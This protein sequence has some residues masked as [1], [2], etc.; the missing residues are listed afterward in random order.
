M[1]RTCKMISILLAAIMIVQLVSTGLPST[2]SIAQAGPNG[3]LLFATSPNDNA[4]NV[5]PNAVLQLQFDENVVRGTGSAAVTIRRV[6]DNSIAESFV[7]A[8]SSAVTIGSDRQV[9]IRPASS[10]LQLNT[11]YYI[12]IDPG[13]FRNANGQNYAGISDATV[14]NFTVTAVDNRAPVLID[15]YPAQSGIIEMGGS[16]Q[17]EFDETVYASSGNVT[18]QRL[19][20]NGTVVDTELIG[21][22]TTNIRGSGSSTITITPSTPL[23]PSSSYRVS[24]SSGAFRDASGNS[25]TGLSNWT[26]STSGPPMAM[27][28]LSPPDDATGVSS[29]TALQMTFD[30]PVA[31]GTGTIVIKNVS[32]NATVREYNVATSNLV[33]IDVNDSRVVRVTNPNLTI[34]QAYYVLVDQGAFVSASNPAVAFQG[35]TDATQWNFSTFPGMDT[36]PPRVTELSPS[37]AHNSG[38]VTALNTR[39]EMK[40]SEP[41]YPGSGNIVIRNRQNHA[42]L[43]SIPVTSSQVT[44]GGTDKILIT[45]NV[46]YVNNT[47]YYVQVGGQAF[48]DAAGNNYAGIPDTDQTT[49]RFSVTQDTTPPAISSLS[50][51]NG[52]TNVPRTG[53]LTATFNEPIQ[54]GTGRI[55]IRGAGSSNVAPS[56]TPAVEIDPDNNRRL[57]LTVPANDPMRVNTS[58]YVEMEEGAVQDIAGNNFGGIL[59]E[60]RWA[61]RT[62]SSDTAL[63]QLSKSEMTGGTRIILTY[64]KELD[65]ASVPSPANFHVTVSNTP[66]TVTAVAVEGTTVTLTLQSGVVFGQEVKVSYTKGTRP[67]QDLSG[68]Q[69]AGLN[70]T[71]VS[72]T[73]STTLPRPTSGTVSGSLIQITFNERLASLS[74]SGAGQFTVYAGGGYRSIASVSTSGTQLLI[75]L[76][77]PITDGQSVTVNYSVGSYPLRD[78][79]GNAVQSFSGFGVRNALDTTPPVLQHISAAG[80]RVTLVYNEALNPGA[81]PTAANYTVLADGTA[82][83][84]SSVEINGSQVFLNLSTSLTSGQLV[85]VSYLGGYPQLTD[86]SGNAAAPFSN[87]A[88]GS[89]SGDNSQITSAY[90]QGQTLTIVFPYT[91]NPAYVPSTAQFYVR[92]QGIV[93]TVT[94]VSVNGSTVTLQLYRSANAGESVSVTYNASGTQLQSTGGVTIASF[95]DYPVTN[96]QGGGSG[97]GGVILP[98]DFETSDR[99]GINIK[100]SVATKHSAMSPAGRVV[101]RY[102]LAADKIQ[103]AYQTIRSGGSSQQPRVQF[104]VPSSEMAAIVAVPFRQL[105]DAKNLA[106]DSVFAVLYKDTT[107]EIPLTSLDFRELEQLAGA[108]GQLLIELEPNQ[109]SE[110]GALMSAISRTRAQVMVSPMSFEL[111][112]SVGGIDKPVTSFPGYIT[113]TVRTAVGL[114]PRKTAAVWLDP[115]TNALSYVPTKVTSSGGATTI[116]Y[117]RKGNSAYAVINGLQDYSDL[118][119][120]WGR[121]DILMLANKFVAE[122]RTVTTFDPN[123]AV[124]RGEFAVFIARGL[125]LSGDKAAASRFSDVNTGSTMAAYIGAVSKAGIVEGLPDGTFRAEQ[126]ITRQEMAA[127]MIRA[128]GTAGVRIDLSQS[129]GTYLSRFKDSGNV[130]PWARDDLARAVDAGIING[131]TADTVSP[132][133]DATRAQAV[134]MIKRMLGHIGF[135]DV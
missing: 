93:Q 71:V 55:L 66:R 69:A 87:Q 118:A 34:N 41:V 23:A 31:K 109:T 124:T 120:H 5:S 64:N 82:R 30:Q 38:T 51:D 98:E 37:A 35:I 13:A 114:D 103:S 95:T 80:T 91:L 126:S 11:E 2:T 130:A 28:A 29:L 36:I 44:G 111:S 129:S 112:A 12:L 57:I 105:E 14:W 39:L 99:G 85:Q 45:P 49:W 106:A 92:L 62:V 33:S 128:A 63:P 113:R 59:N 1:L 9:R 121:N 81:V 61:F 83:T 110:S 74:S 73:Q 108:S 60:Y 27:P 65:P 4:T 86:L 84:V 54:L 22:T 77:S 79:S 70:G 78:V 16:L 127:M 122:G 125:G 53:R 134:V 89:V 116:S 17:L 101:Q 135:M 76:S 7:V 132:R 100:T 107:Y 3:P 19:N 42:V 94:N 43:T 32:N 26:F 8:T 131:M 119:N 104:T 102:N 96:G 15:R 50:P 90:V 58:Y 6:A 72:N 48:R 46:Q 67:I 97:G 115:E 52:A 18:I 117:M 75:T 47:S 56:I 88:A 123:R 68:N 25:Y 21:V 40:F 24:V 10:T 133:S 20:Q